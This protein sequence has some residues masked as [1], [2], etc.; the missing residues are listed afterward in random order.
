V[1]ELT[2]I[3]NKRERPA[4]LMF[5]QDLSVIYV[6]PEA[7]KILSSLHSSDT[8]EE[9]NDIEIPEEII[10]T[11]KEL[12]EKLRNV[13]GSLIT[14]PSNT[15]MITS[16]DGVSYAVRAFLLDKSPRNIDIA[17]IMV[18]LERIVAKHNV[19]FEKVQQSFD[20]TKREI[21]V[22]RLLIP[23]FTNKEISDEL[24][25]SEHTVKD[26]I[27]NIMR[28]VKAKSRSQIIHNISE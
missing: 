2:E 6:N 27:K 10:K 5:N 4:V 11:C 3:I 17:Q 13:Y 16:H 23:G 25:V 7:K 20:L 18:L 9:H 21:E 12:K 1:D 19:D 26:H 22:I 24:F 28:K 8:Q 14:D 15:A